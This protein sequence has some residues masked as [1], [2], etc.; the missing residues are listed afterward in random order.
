MR[1]G[2]VE[3][4]LVFERGRRMAVLPLRDGY[5]ERI[6]ASA[7]LRV[8]MPPQRRSVYW[9]CGHG[10]CSFDAYGNWGMSDIARDLARDGYRNLPLDL[11]AD[12]QMPADCALV[13]VA[14]A[15]SEFS[16]VETGRLE[17][18]LRQGGRLLV[19]LGSADSGGV[20]TMLS[21]WGIRPTAASFAGARTLSGT[22]VIVSNFSDHAIASPLQGSQVV[23]EKPVA[24]SPS[25]AADAVGGADR[26][27][28]SPLATVG[29]ACVAAVAE[30]GAGAGADLS[31]RP[32]RIVA[33]GDVSFVMNG[34]LASRANANRDFFLNCVAYLSGTDAVTESG[35]EPDRLVAGL[36]REAR[37]RFVLVTA[38]A[39]PFLAFSAI[40]LAVARRRMRE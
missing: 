8:A 20:A 3:D 23:L 28:F 35:T 10:E 4:S 34:Q 40:L 24:F 6:C 2:A 14:G 22:D 39:F 31:I 18:Y 33:V 27:E 37:V 30:R 17:T 7:I 15:K 13:V 12:A 9:T 1:S 36:D 21:G 5:G 26:I 32:T 11:S 29:G 38:A 19:L 25:A 16:R